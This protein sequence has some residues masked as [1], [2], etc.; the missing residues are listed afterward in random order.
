M[1]IEKTTFADEALKVRQSFTGGRKTRKHQQASSKVAADNGADASE[2]RVNVNIIPRIWLRDVEAQVREM[3]TFFTANSL[4]WDDNGW[5]IIPA[6]SYDSVMS[7]LD[8]MAIELDRLKENVVKNW[9][10]VKQN[11][12]LKLGDLFD[13]NT[14]P[15]QGEFASAFQRE[16]EVEPIPASGHFTANVLTKAQNRIAEKLEQRV[17]LQLAAAHHDLWMRLSKAVSHACERLSAYSV[18]GDG[19]VSN[20]LY[21]SVITNLSDLVPV[22]RSLNIA[23]DAQLNKVVNDIERHLVKHPVGVLKNDDGLRKIVAKHASRINS[24]ILGESVKTLVDQPWRVDPNLSTSLGTAPE[25]E[26]VPEP[27]TVLKNNDSA[28]TILEKLKNQIST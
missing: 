1:K 3:R 2:A 12:Y 4:P 19:R 14:F 17:A 8:S 13:E 5:R 10:Q 6:D 16:V 26:I 18:D 24:D 22:A 23:D 20:K 25:P 7:T 28:L 21:D 15:T 27:E 11:A 9:D